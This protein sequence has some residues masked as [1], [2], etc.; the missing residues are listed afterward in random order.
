MEDY[1]VFD[2]E[3]VK[4]DI[5]GDGEVVSSLAYDDGEGMKEIYLTEVDASG[6]NLSY[7]AREFGHTET[8]LE[9]GTVSISAADEAESVVEAVLGDEDNVSDLM[10]GGAENL[11]GTGTASHYRR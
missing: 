1:E 10:V 6:E 11:S 8:A 3:T 5:S 2:V 9:S 7:E 4:D